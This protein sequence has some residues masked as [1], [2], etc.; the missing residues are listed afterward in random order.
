MEPGYHRSKKRSPFFLG[1]E[2]AAWLLLVAD[3][4]AIIPTQGRIRETI[5]LVLAFLLSMGFPLSWGKLAGGEVLHLVEYELVL[6][7]A[8]LGLSASRAQCWYSRLLRDRSVQMQEFQE[9]HCECGRVRTSWKEAWRVDAHVDESGVGVGGWWPRA[10]GKWFAIK[11]TPENA[12]WA[13]KWKGVSCDRHSGSIGLA[14]GPPGG[15]AQELNG[16]KTVIQAPAL[17]D[18]RGNGYVI[19]KLMTTRFLLCAIVMELAAQAEYRGVRMEAQWT[20]RDG[21]QEVDDLSN[22]RKDGFD[23]EKEV[24]VD[25]EDRSWFVLPLLLESGQKV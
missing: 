9:R 1:Q 7:E 5:F 19:N 11:V 24:K 4:L 15:P 6:T 2:H 22:L 8:S 18:N 3:D 16:T 13:L 25:L 20:P 17:T 14:S 10:N 21:N 23:P 12:P